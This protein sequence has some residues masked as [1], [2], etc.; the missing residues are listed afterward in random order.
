MFTFDND[1]DDN[2]KKSFGRENPLF[3][4]DNDEKDIFVMFTFDNDNDEM[5]LPGQ[6]LCLSMTMQ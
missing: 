5:A 3:D 2:E 4:N 6:S 1:N